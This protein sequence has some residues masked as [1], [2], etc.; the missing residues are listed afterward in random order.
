[1]VSSAVPTA[2]LRLS[3]NQEN[4][5]VAKHVL[6]VSRPTPYSLCRHLCLCSDLM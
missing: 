5:Q 2:V 3:L 1:M 4:A 6:H